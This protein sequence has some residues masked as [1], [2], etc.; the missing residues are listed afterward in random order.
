MNK[1]CLTIDENTDLNIPK[2]TTLTHDR[3]VSLT[4]GTVES[5]YLLDVL[6]YFDEHNLK[7]CLQQIFNKLINGGELILQ[8]PDMNQLLIAINF[9]KIQPQTGKR[10]IYSGRTIMHSMEEIIDIIKMSG[11]ECYIKKY[12]NIFEYYLEFKKL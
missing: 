10:I 5:V 3:F 7:L 4:D 8:G 2:Y 9:N 12:I 11:F 6:D 1:I